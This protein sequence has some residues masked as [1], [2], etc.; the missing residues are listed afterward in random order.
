MAT[1]VSA[2]ESLK[3][4][5]T[6]RR[7]IARSC[8]PRS[9]SKRA[10]SS[11]S[12]AAAWSLVDCT[13]RKVPAIIDTA[14]ATAPVAPA[15]STAWES[16]AEKATP[17]TR[18]KIE[19]VPS[20]MP[21]TIEPTEATKERR[22]CPNS[23]RGRSAEPSSLGRRSAGASLFLALGVTASYA[24]FCLMLRTTA[25]CTAARCSGQ[26]A[27]AYSIIAARYKA[28]RVGVIARANGTTAS[29]V[30]AASGRPGGLAHKERQSAA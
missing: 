1:T 7:W 21:N 12:R 6:R 20:S 30:L 14:A 23:V 11:A 2:S 26:K 4:A 29:A 19:T 16:G 3:P 17:K 8:W 28:A 18:P 27:A 10:L 9:A 25:Q 5:E 24:S 13:S 22:I 15:S